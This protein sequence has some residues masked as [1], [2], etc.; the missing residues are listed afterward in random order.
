MAHAHYI[1]LTIS[2]S[3]FATVLTIAPPNTAD[4]RAFIVKA[5]NDQISLVQ[6]VNN[7]V[8][9]ELPLFNT[10]HVHHV[11]YDMRHNCVFYATYEQIVRQCLNGNQAAEVLVSYGATYIQGLA[12]DWMSQVLYFTDAQRHKIEAI[13]VSV[14]DHSST[15]R[16]RSTIYQG[17]E[18]SVPIRIAVHPTRG[19]LYWTSATTII[20]IGLDGGHERQLVEGNQ[21]QEPTEIAID[22]EA[23][24]V[25]W[26]DDRLNQIASSDL[27]GND[28]RIHSTYNNY[29]PVSE[30]SVHKNL[31]YY[32][33]TYGFSDSDINAVNKGIFVFLCVIF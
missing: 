15:N 29:V 8:D 23:D 27:D 4:L 2:L 1:I 22:Y 5:Q 16:L 6:L 25:Y 31:I 13:N 26:N 11:E 32:R 19:F 17:D 28:V 3:L 18:D 12:Y 21:I 10:T 20:R 24:R 14:I 7:N 9:A 33:E 30:L